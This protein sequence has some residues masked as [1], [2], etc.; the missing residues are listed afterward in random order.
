MLEI[1]FVPSIQGSVYDHV[2]GKIWTA[3]DIGI[4]ERTCAGMQNGFMSVNTTLQ[5][6]R[7][8]LA[9]LYQLYASWGVDF[10]KQTQLYM[11]LPKV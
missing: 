10:G 9:D 2:N 4:K 6:G 5:A 8:F 11:L 7:F 3:Q 1:S